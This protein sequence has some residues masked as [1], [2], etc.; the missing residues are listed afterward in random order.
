VTATKTRHSRNHRRS[1]WWWLGFVLLVAWTIGTIFPVL[2]IFLL[3]VR[4]TQDVYNHPLGLSGALHWGNYSEA[5]NGAPGGTAFYHYLI[6][7]VVSVVAALLIA[8]VLGTVTSYALVRNTSPG[9]TPLLL[10]IFVIALVFPLVVLVIPIFGLLDQAALLNSPAAI[11]V[12]YG[13]LACP[14]VVLITYSAFLEFPEELIDAGNLDGLSEWGVF[15]RLVLPLN[16]GP[17]AACLVLTMIFV[18][19]EAQLGIIALQQAQSKT[20]AVGLLGLQGQYFTNQ[21]VLFSGLA[22]ATLPILVVYLIMQKFIVR[23]LALGGALR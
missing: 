11:G 23:G 12:V 17:I 20:L 14:T 10:R 13:V 5:W 21:G 9:K 18:W 15:V 6:N 8:I 3:S 1:V 19:G 4:G 2:S 7:S 16:R 22:L